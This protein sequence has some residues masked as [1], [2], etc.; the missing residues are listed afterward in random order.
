MTHSRVSPPR[1]RAVRTAAALAL[2]A[3]PLSACS[4]PGSLGLGAES[5]SS[6]GSGT[7]ASGGCEAAT[8]EIDRIVADAQASAPQLVEDLLS[9]KQIDPVGTLVAP[10]LES[11]DAA[12]ASTNDSEL[13]AAIAETRGV[14]EGVAADVSGLP[15]PDIGG[16]DL[17]NLESLGSLGELQQY[18]T[19]LS[20]IVTERL[21]E[22]QESGAQLQAACQAG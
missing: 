3:I 10:V 7:T 21:P 4:L 2:L 14:W 5:P 12:A 20:R 22:I 16:I 1:F 19:E 11:L 13:L 9:G 6:G 18:G 15:T 17:G 8:A